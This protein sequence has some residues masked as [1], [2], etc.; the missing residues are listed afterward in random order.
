MQAP[1]T[2]KRFHLRAPLF[3]MPRFKFFVSNFSLNFPPF[4][5]FHHFTFFISSVIYL[6]LRHLYYAN[7]IKIGA[8]EAPIPNYSHHFPSL[9]FFVLLSFYRFKVYSNITRRRTVGA[10]QTNYQT[11]YPITIRQLATLFF[12]SELE[13]KTRIK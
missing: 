7:N 11:R 13:Q 2:E 6:S 12:F 9:F 4:Y 10:Q 3:L 5:V 1:T 8:Y